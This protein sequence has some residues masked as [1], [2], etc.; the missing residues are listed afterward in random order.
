VVIGIQRSERQHAMK[1]ER[2]AA[3]P[4]G[5]RQWRHAADGG[6]FFYEMK[7]L[8]E[9]PVELLVNYW[10]S[11]AGGR[12]FDILVDGM[13]IATQK[14]ERNRPERFY[15]EIYP[16]PADLTKGKDKVTVRFQAHPGRTAGGIFDCRILK[17]E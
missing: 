8:P 9:R 16:I 12:E 4:F 5:G 1:G 6:W 3:G 17:K 2:T 13:K 15:D 7:V 10:G 14:L 11:D